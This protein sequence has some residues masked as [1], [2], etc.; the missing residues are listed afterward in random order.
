MTRVHRRQVQVVLRS[1]VCR[2]A[3]EAGLVSDAPRMPSLPKK[4]AKILNSRKISRG[5]PQAVDGN[6]P[7]PFPPTGKAGRAVQSDVGAP[8]TDPPSQA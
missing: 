8:Y 3:V 2:Y 5:M 6:G 7:R 4:S 1:I